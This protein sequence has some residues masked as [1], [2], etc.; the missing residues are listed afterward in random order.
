[1]SE[2]AKPDD[3]FREAIE[4]ARRADEAFDLFARI[5]GAFPSKTPYMAARAARWEKGDPNVVKV[6]HDDRLECRLVFTQGQR[7]LL[8]TKYW[9]A[10]GME[11]PP[12]ESFS[13][14]EEFVDLIEGW[15][16]AYDQWQATRP[17][18]QK[19]RE[20]ALGSVVNALEKLDQALA[21][22]DSAALGFLYAKA[23]DAAAEHG[24]QISEADD[25]IASMVDHPLRAQVE[26][27]ELRHKM[28]KVLGV[29]V[30]ATNKA[31]D[32]LPKSDR[33][34]NDWRLALAA[35][36]LKRLFLEHRIAFETT[37]TG[38]AADALRA[39]FD[40]AGLDVEKVSYWLKK[41][42]DDPRITPWG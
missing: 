28:R 26:A 35:I 14:A 34:E 11:A 37:E 27:G 4:F 22:L 9:A 24:L 33:I 1:M 17:E 7:E 19:N 23:V 10:R 12:A 32:E 6:A 21:Q 29:I 2:E 25:R 41:A 30:E 16:D 38:F 36:P 13:L 3:P 5:P 18:P 15:A 20:R 40:L 31:R 42:A 8:I 39:I